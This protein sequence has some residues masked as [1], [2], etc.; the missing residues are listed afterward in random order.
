MMPYHFQ[1]D[2]RGT[3]FSEVLI[4]MAI[5]PICLLGAMGA[6]HAAERS[7]GQGATASRALAMVEARIEAKRAARWDLLLL[8][9]L[10]VDGLPDVVMHD[11]GL[12]GDLAGGDGTYSATWEQDRVLLTWTVTPTRGANLSAS[13][14]VVIEA[15]A[16]YGSGGQQQEVRVATVRA[17]PSFVGR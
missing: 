11:D 12:A 10:N 1:T 16:S 7:I 8:D 13:G 9:D 17:N 14:Y 3:S 6:F 2:C 15:R 5:V 4:A